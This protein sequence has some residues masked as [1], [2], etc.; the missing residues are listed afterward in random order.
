MTTSCESAPFGS[1][2]VA[3]TQLNDPRIVRAGDPAEQT[4]TEI[5]IRVPEVHAIERVEE[6]GPEL[7]P[8][9]FRERHRERLEDRKVEIGVTG[10]AP[11]VAAQAPEGPGRVGG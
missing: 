7:R 8:L 2:R 6:L 11:G 4:G 9:V 5:G 3:Q 1:E 10:S